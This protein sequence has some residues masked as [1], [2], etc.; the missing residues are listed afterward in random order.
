MRI[1]ASRTSIRNGARASAA[2]VPQHPAPVF[3]GRAILFHFRHN[4]LLKL[5]VLRPVLV[6]FSIV[7]LL[8]PRQWR[9]HADDLAIAIDTDGA[10]GF[11]K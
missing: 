7:K 3:L 10:R 9:V 8:R 1:F 4:P 5:F 2:E 11:K 6:C